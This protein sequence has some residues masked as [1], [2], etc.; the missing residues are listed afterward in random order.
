MV[1]FAEWLWCEERNLVDP[2]VLATYEQA[3]QDGLESLIRRTQDPELRAAFETMR[4]C[5]IRDRRGGCTRFADYILGA[6]IRNGCHQRFDIDDCLQ[7][8]CF[9]L[10]SPIG[11]RG[12]ARRSL[13]DFDETAPYDLRFG[14]PLAARF[15]TYLANELRTITA[16]RI[17]ALQRTQ[18]PDTLSIGYG[19]K[20]LVSPDEIPGRAEN[21][22]QELVSDIVEL[23]RRRSTPAL[24][25]VDLFYSICAGEGT[26]A[27][28]ARF[29]RAQT[30][31]GR[32]IIV[33]VIE[34]YARQTQ[35]WQLL[36][37][38]DRLRN[39]D[40][41][42]AATPQQ[43]P[44]PIKPKL[45]PDEQDYRS[46]VDVIERS[47]RQAN[48][49]VLGRLRRRWMERPPRDPSSPY[50]NRLADVLARMVADGVLQK[51]GARYIPG[52]LYAKWL[53]TPQPGAV[54]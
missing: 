54:V 28:R 30:D 10:L 34:Q 45:P 41:T 52:P 51:Q 47:G 40:A 4:S 12:F 6:L 13:F 15:K 11:E 1:S 32:Q 9:R 14:N 43:A 39:V 22:D 42:R 35:N 33:G 16:N 31:S 29:G 37:L 3:F 49:A 27:Q 24:P 17:P 8:I 38:L 53:G 26:R 36:K 46:L 21:N 18:R 2:G 23:L 48:L 50:P 20:G 7:R 44:K 5:P 19:E 25:L